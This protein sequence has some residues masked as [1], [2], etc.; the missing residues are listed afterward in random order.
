MSRLNSANPKQ[1]KLIVELIVQAN[2]APARYLREEHQ[3]FQREVM[4]P[5]RDAIRNAK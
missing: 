3:V 2:K 4:Q 5:I 1:R